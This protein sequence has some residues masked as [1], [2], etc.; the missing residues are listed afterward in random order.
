MAPNN[1][2]GAGVE[3]NNPSGDTAENDNDV[4]FFN[5]F[6]VLPAVNDHVEAD[7]NDAMLYASLSPS[8]DT[9]NM[10]LMPTPPGLLADGIGTP[11]ASEASLDLSAGRSNSLGNADV[12][13]VGPDDVNGKFTDVSDKASGDRTLGLSTRG[14]VLS[15]AT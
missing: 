1:E 15:L 4:D 2:F 9:N 13:G 8:A 3:Q 6:V 14:D 5:A 11:L 10:D 12:L 7:D